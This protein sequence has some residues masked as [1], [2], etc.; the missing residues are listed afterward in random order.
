MGK[1]AGDI[2]GGNG[3]GLHDPGNERQRKDDQ[4]QGRA[5]CVLFLCFHGIGWVDEVEGCVRR[6]LP[7]R[8][9]PAEMSILI[10]LISPED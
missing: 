9:F 6:R 5:L 3:V 4:G 2:E 1:G 7:L 8:A 10:F